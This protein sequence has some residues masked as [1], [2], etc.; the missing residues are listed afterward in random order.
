MSQLLQPVL[1][2]QEALAQHRVQCMTKPSSSLERLILLR[3]FESNGISCNVCWATIISIYR[4]QLSWKDQKRGAVWTGAISTGPY[5]ALLSLLHFASTQC[6]WYCG[7]KIY[8]NRRW[9]MI[10][11]SIIIYHCHN[12]RMRTTPHTQV[13]MSL[14]TW[15]RSFQLQKIDATQAEK[16]QVLI[17]ISNLSC[18]SAILIYTRNNSWIHKTRKNFWN[19]NFNEMK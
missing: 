5:I 16:K 8:M 6:L 14:R 3:M 19:F 17:L 11:H 15:N 13:M 12:P 4:C 18:K 1:E 2:T 10:M 7:V 9:T